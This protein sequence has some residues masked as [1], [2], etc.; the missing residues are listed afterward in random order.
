MRIEPTR[1]RLAKLRTEGLVDASL[2]GRPDGPWCYGVQIAF[3]RPELRG[4]RPESAPWA[5]I[6]HHN[7]SPAEQDGRGAVFAVEAVG[8][9]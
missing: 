4:R 3:E 5:E 8:L 6:A 9:L 7:P 1:R 2:W